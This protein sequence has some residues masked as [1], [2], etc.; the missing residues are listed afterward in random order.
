MNILEF[1]KDPNWDSPFFKK[2]ARNDTGQST[3]HQGG[4]VIPQDLRKFFPQLTGIIN[5]DNPTIDTRIN[6][7]LYLAYE[8][9]DSVNT[10][11]QYQTWRGARTPESRLTD[12]LGPLR[13]EASGDDYLIFQ[14]FKDSLNIFRLILIRQGTREYNYLSRILGQRRWGVIEETPMSEN[15]L[16]NAL[17]EQTVREHNP[18]S[19]FDANPGFTQSHSKSV[20][21]SY[22]FRIKVF[23]L[24][25]S[26]CCIC[27]SRLETPRG[28]LELD[29]AH[30]VPR[31]KFGTDDSR[32]GLA[33]C[34]RHHWAFDKGLF[35]VTQERRIIVPENI[36]SINSNNPLRE[37][38]NRYIIEANNPQL[39]ASDEA[40]EWHRI[41]IAKI[42]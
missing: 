9:I 15:D 13:N 23:E 36:L 30:I 20:A 34:K 1:L 14:R 31:S 40:F 24:Y 18:F 5:A 33:L 7:Q 3:G 25:Q 17:Q 12:S 27:G 37:I 42:L 29:A 10:R 26:K 39:I 4:L 19:L 38:N 16:N 8:Q 41:N 2:L 35:G 21:R 6:A 28:L 32:N 22:S 11:Y